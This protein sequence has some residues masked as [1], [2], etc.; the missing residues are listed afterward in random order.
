LEAQAA[1]RRKW[2]ERDKRREQI[3]VRVLVA[4]AERDQTIERTERQ[5][6]QALVELTGREGLSIRE[7][8]EWC[9][10]Q[11]SVGEATRLR[12]AANHHD[13]TSAHPVPDDDVAR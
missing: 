8:V 11:V 12:R 3:A 10:G 6:G 2:A 1:R 4:L 7:A 5:A 13:A 9:G